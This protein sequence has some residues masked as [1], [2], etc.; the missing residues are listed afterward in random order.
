MQVSEDTRR[1][2]GRDYLQ[3]YASSSNNP[4][5]G[6]KDGLNEADQNAHTIV[7]MILN[8]GFQY[9][10]KTHQ[11]VETPDVDF[12]D[13]DMEGEIAMQP[14]IYDDI[15]EQTLNRQM[16]KMP[17]RLDPGSAILAYLKSKVTY[18]KDH[19][20]Y[21]QDDERRVFTSRLNKLLTK[22]TNGTMLTLAQKTQKHRA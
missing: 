10:L 22:V 12:K 8:G 19:K 13:V 1:I 17:C 7:S 9:N 2:M 14:K 6:W 4:F 20:R 11:M 18:P 21:T 5:K 16:L 15:R 3:Q